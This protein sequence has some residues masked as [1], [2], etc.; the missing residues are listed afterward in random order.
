MLLLAPFGRSAAIRNAEVINSTRNRISSVKVFQ[1]LLYRRLSILQEYLLFM[2]LHD[3]YPKFP[4]YPLGTTG[5]MIP[6]LHF[7]S[8]VAKK[9]RIIFLFIEQKLNP[10]Y[11]VNCASLSFRF[12][13]GTTDWPDLSIHIQHPPRFCRRK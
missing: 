9:N 7:Q 11:Y 10:F 3:S 5:T 4:R 1:V 13:H 6:R 12:D 2:S 8:L